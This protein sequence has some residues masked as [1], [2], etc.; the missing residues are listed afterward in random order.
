VLADTAPIVAVIVVVPEPEG[1]AAPTLST[2]ATVTSDDVHT[3]CGVMVS[4][5]PSL[6]CP[7]ALNC[8][9]SPRATVGVAGVS[10]IEVRVAP[11]IV[12]CAAPT[13]P[14][15]TAPIVAVPGVR[16]IAPPKLPGTL[17]MIPTATDDD[18]HVTDGVRSC[19]VPSCSVPVAV[20]RKKVPAA[21]VSVPGVIAM[22][23]NGSTFMVAVAD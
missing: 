12:A 23:V 13:T 4:L 3:T 1:V 22:D 6:K 21:T 19:V 8:C 7:T 15:S 10:M 18:V 20:K 2:I 9:E 14:L 17:L 16:P 11:V 5:L